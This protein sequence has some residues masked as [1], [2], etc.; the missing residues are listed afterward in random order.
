MGLIMIDNLLVEIKNIWDKN[1]KLLFWVIILFILALIIGYIGLFDFYMNI[2]YNS[3][4]E[5]VSSGNIQLTTLSVLSHN[6]FSILITY[7]LGIFF[8]LGSLFSLI[9]NGAFIGYFASRSVASGKLL[10]FILLILPHGIFEFLGLFIVTVAGLRLGHF[11]IRMC[12]GFVNGIAS[13][14]L[15]VNLKYNFTHYISEIKESL[16]L[17]LISILLFSIAAVIEV[18]VTL[19]FYNFI[20]TLI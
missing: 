15:K 9:Q 3:F 13:A 16:K 12:D 14:D 6:L 1:K 17:L 5:E 10:D 11:I 19:D 20:M 18:N 4:N 7:C 2:L 8:G